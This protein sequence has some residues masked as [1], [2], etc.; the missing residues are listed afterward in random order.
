M[1]STSAFPQDFLIAQWLSCAKACFIIP[2][3]IEKDLRK[4]LLKTQPPAFVDW[5]CQFTNDLYLAKYGYPTNKPQIEPYTEIYV[6]NLLKQTGALKYCSPI[7]GKPTLCITHDID[8]LDISAKLILKRLI[9]ERK[10]LFFKK[11]EKCF[12]PSLNKLLKLSAPLSP[13][14]KSVATVF[15]S[16]AQKSKNPLNWPMQ[17]LMDP[18]Y[19]VEHP[20][21]KDFICLL[22]E[23]QCDI[24]LHGSFYSLTQNFLK[25][26]KKILESATKQEINVLR[27]HWLHLPGK[28]AWNIIKKSNFKI[29]S[30][31]GWNGNVGFRGGM[32]RPFEVLIDNDPLSTIWE[33]PLL[34]MDGPL[35]CDLDLHRKDIS[36]FA[37]SLLTKVLQRKGCVSINWHDRAAHPA[38]NWDGVF[39]E[40]ISFAEKKGFHFLTLKEAVKVQLETQQLSNS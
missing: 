15:A 31:L 36:A 19:T 17:W 14:S 3:E 8:H 34:L 7:I 2:E 6:E 23:A 28:K 16:S 24:G 26:E 40:I 4:T 12:L 27:Q 21:F 33:I 13:S 32:A 11:E 18:S 9:S 5:S 35:F 10:I 22:Q 29:D 25:E 38:Y 39:E 1:R 37:K 30:T 20:Q